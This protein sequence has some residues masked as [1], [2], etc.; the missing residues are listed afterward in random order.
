MFEAL[1]LENKKWLF[2][3]NLAGT[4]TWKSLLEGE[5]ALRRTVSCSDK[6]LW[7]FLEEPL[8]CSQHFKPCTAC[9][10]FSWWR[11]E[12]T[13]FETSVGKP[14]ALPSP[15]RV[16]HMV[17]LLTIARNSYTFLKR[18]IIWKVLGLIL[19]Q[20]ACWFFPCETPE[21]VA[22]GEQSF[23]KYTPANGKTKLKHPLMKRLHQRCT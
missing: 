8:V 16:F 6:N 22:V 9:L 1:H 4:A 17:V 21:K 18:S 15:T 5:L 14:T 2:L 19:T 20:D 12:F 7:L 10:H 11:V 23:I 3:V 13:L